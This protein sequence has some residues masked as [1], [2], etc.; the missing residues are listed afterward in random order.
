MNDLLGNDNIIRDI[1][2]R[3][4]TSLSQTNELGEKRFNTINYNLSDILIDNR[5]KTNGYEK[6]QVI[7]IL[8]LRS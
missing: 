5:T 8:S 2:T 7:G 6:I 4:K 3:N 1:S